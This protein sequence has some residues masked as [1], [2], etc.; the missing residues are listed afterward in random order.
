MNRS[1][2]F[3]KGLGVPFR[4]QIRTGLDPNAEVSDE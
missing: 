4:Q 1:G 3:N 2:P